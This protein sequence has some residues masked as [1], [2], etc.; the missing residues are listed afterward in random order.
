MYIA[1]ILANFYFR[2]TQSNAILIF[3]IIFT[4]TEQIYQTTTS[5]RGNGYFNKE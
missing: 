5:R 3:V 1:L 4:G 2:F